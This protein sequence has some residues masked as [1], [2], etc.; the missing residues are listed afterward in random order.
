MEIT[1]K[2]EM[3]AAAMTALMALVELA[4]HGKLQA[5][6]PDQD[7]GESA[8]APA[9]APKAAEPE[10]VAQTPTPEPM[11]AP[12]AAATGIPTS[13]RTFTLDELGRA[14]A[15]LMDT[16]KATLEDL[17]SAMGAFGVQTL[18]DLPEQYYDGF[19]AKL[20]ELGADL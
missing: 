8:A 5:I 18:T 20:R 2:I 17:K 16:G 15:L 14:G 4:Q 19:A 11:A 1:V 3:G 13:A 12:A 9:S 6:S 10:P 7:T